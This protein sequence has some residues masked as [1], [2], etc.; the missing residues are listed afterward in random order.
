MIGY[1]PG[2]DRT[3]FLLS[4]GAGSYE[5]LTTL[6]FPLLIIG[7]FVFLIFLLLCYAL[8]LGSLLPTEA[9][10]ACLR[11]FPDTN[12]NHIGDNQIVTLFYF[13]HEPL[14]FNS[15][16]T[17]FMAYVPRINIPMCCTKHRNT[18]C[19]GLGA[20]SVE[21]WISTRSRHYSF[22]KFQIQFK[23]VFKIPNHQDIYNAAVPIHNYLLHPLCSPHIG[24]MTSI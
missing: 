4:I 19:L 3:S 13:F 1:L 20:C 16:V 12:F 10:Y 7:L 8:I 24:H 21:P 9:F 5:L 14:F 17:F 15:P 22:E 18:C 6:N 23:L 2:A 11:F